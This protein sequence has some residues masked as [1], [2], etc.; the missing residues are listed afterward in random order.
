MYI[1]KEM[2]GVIK[3]KWDSN[4]EQHINKG[5]AILLITK[6]YQDTMNKLGDDYTD[7]E[8]NISLQRR[9]R[10]MLEDNWIKS[11]LKIEYNKERSYFYDIEEPD[12]IS[13]IGRIIDVLDMRY[14][15]Q[16]LFRYNIEIVA[17]L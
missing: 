13:M 6:L 14:E 12:A 11:E 7:Y 17:Y 5:D 16:S 3:I 2:I 8:L 10:N 1:I 15:L 9:N 4:G